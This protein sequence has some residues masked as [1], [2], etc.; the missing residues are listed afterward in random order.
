VKIIIPVLTVIA[1][2]GCQSTNIQKFEPLTNEPNAAKLDIS[3]NLVGLFMHGKVTQLELFNGCYDKNYDTENVI[4]HIVSEH[5]DEKSNIVNIPT[6]EKLY[7]QYGTTEPN[8]N[9]HSQ[10]SFTPLKGESYKIQYEMVFAGCEITVIHNGSKLKDVEFF[11]STSGYN[12]KWRKC[13]K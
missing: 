3:A 12:K 11:D 6:G 1:L 13:S 8:W 10:F 5:K 2:Q 4:G 7:F 9:C